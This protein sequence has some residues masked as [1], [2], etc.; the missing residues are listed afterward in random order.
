MINSIKIENNII[1]IKILDNNNSNTNTLTLKINI[2]DKSLKHFR[3]LYLDIHKNKNHLVT[4]DNFLIEYIDNHL[5]ISK[6]SFEYKINRNS[7][8]ID[9]IDKIIINLMIY[10]NDLES[11]NSPNINEKFEK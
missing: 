5:K 3:E 8:I 11:H 4:D 9:L 2:N 7:D 10:Q 1:I 6:D